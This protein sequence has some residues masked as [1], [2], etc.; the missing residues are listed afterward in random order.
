MDERTIA[1]RFE[2]EGYVSPLD[3]LTGAEV[4]RYRHVYEQIEADRAARNITARPTQQHLEH[5]AFWELVH[6][7]RVLQLA[8]AAVGP[9]VILIATGFFSKPAGAIDKFVAWHQDTTYWGLEPA[10][11]VTLWIAIDDS[12]TENGCMRVIP[13]THHAILPHGKAARA[14]NMLA[15]DQAIDA[16]AI[17]E[18][19][20][21]DLVLQAGQASLHHG[22]TVHGSNPNRSTRRRCGMTLRFTR[23]DVKPVAGVFRDKPLLLL[24]EDRFG[25]FEYVPRPAFAKAPA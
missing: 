4:A 19:R 12:D 14:G 5:E 8:R 9:D 1:G 23:P 15:H 22:M 7:P 2:R 3:V 20:A 6:H 21:V 11:A 13:G 25:H 24:G 17:D 18:S 16:D 10:Y